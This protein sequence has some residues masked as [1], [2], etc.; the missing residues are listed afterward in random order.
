MSITEILFVNAM[1]GVI[2]S[3][4]LSTAPMV[5]QV[6]HSRIADHQ[7]QRSG[8]YAM[9]AI[10]RDLR[11]ARAVLTAEAARIVIQ[12]PQR[13]T[14]RRV[15]VPLAD[16]DTVAYFLGTAAGQPDPNGEVLWR[17]APA[18]TNSPKKVALVTPGG[19]AFGYFPQGAPAS[20]VESVVLEL[21]ATQTALGAHQPHS[22]SD[23]KSYVS[24]FSTK[25]EVLLRN[26]PGWY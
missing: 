26:R 4:V 8:E 15:Q 21:T 25:Q 18:T 22:G 3:L 6:Y 5:R 11:T 23:N 1:F 2:I 20:E 16:G 13:D 14:A 9:Q 7:T 12:L 24:R 10:A 19:I 17:A